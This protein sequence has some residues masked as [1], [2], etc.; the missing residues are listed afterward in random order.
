MLSGSIACHKACAAISRLVKEGFDVHTAATESALRFTGVAALEGLSRRPVFTDLWEPGRALDHI[1][2]TRIC[3][4]AIVCPASANTLNRLAAGLADDPIGCLH[5]A[6]DLQS[7]PWMVAPAMN[8]QMWR[9]PATVA[10][11]RRL[12][13]FGVR[14]LEPG[15]GPQACG[16]VGPGRLPEPDEIVDFILENLR[17]KTG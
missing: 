17:G 15:S 2:L 13:E 7:K 16:D 14:V 6:W 4:A 9:H 11:V 5:L 1:E 3:D 12:K 10:S 8:Q